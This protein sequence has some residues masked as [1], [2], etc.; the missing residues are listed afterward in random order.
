M[1]TA[2]GDKWRK[3]LEAWSIPQEILNQAPENPWIHP[4]A[5]FQIPQEIENSPSHMRAREALSVDASV[6]DIGCGGGIASFALVPE[7][8]KVIGV[9]H[10]P[11]MLE[12]YSENAMKRNLI[13][14]TFEGFWPQIPQQVPK[15]DVVVSHHVVYNV[16][17]IEEFLLECTNHARNR[18][19]IEMPQQ[20]PLAVSSDLWI[21][22][23]KIQ[24]PETPTPFDLVKVLNDLNIDAQLELWE[25]RMRQ[26]VDLEEMA[27][28][29]RIRLCL[30]QSKEPEVLDI[31]K[32]KPPSEVR[33][34]A[35]IW[36][37]I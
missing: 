1:E 34:L 11:E 32:E 17:K 19:V 26:E 35:T 29:S 22:F 36:W 30:P 33:K 12:M 8:K 13:C 10:Q 7:V 37:D 16:Q 9:D 14:E 15:A 27:H 20:H 21:H 23:W 25:G 4:P 5:L 18:I 28:F 31:L 3:A 6:L 2:S 24:R